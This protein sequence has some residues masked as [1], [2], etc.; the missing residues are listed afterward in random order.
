[1]EQ[2]PLYL[3]I[4]VSIL[5]KC[6]TALN[7][8]KHRYACVLLD[9]FDNITQK[10]CIPLRILFQRLILAAELSSRLGQITKS[11]AE[12]EN[13]LELFNS[14]PDLKFKLLIKAGRMEACVARNNISVKHL[15]EALGLAESIENNSM[16]AEAYFAIAHMFSPKYEGLAFYFLRHAELFYENAKDCRNL[17][18]VRIHRALLSWAVSRN[19]SNLRN[20]DRF[21][22]EAEKLISKI[23]TENLNPHDLTYLKYVKGVIL[24]DEKLLE[25]LLHENVDVDMLPDKCRHGEMIIGICIEKGLFEKAEQ[26]L[27]SYEKDAKKVHGNGIEIENHVRL[28][29][30]LINR[31]ERSVY[32]PFRI[33][34]ESME[35]ANLFDIL[36]HYSLCDE[37]WALDNSEMRCLFP[38]YRQEGQFEAIRMPDNRTILYPCAIAFN[39]F[40]RGQSEYHKMAQPSLYRKGMSE[41]MQFVERVRYEEFKRCVESSPLTNIFQNG[42]YLT[43]PNGCQER[44]ELSVDTLALAQ[45]YGI[46]TELM[47]LTTDKFVAAFFSTTDCKN[48]IYTPI[49]DNRKEPGVFYRYCDTLRL[50]KD[51]SYRLR[52]VGLQP[53]S[54]PGEQKGLVY[55]MRPNENFND[56]VMSKD[57]FTHDSQIASFIFNYMNRSQKLFPKSPLEVHADAILNSS[58]L[59]RD[60]FDAA[61]RE[62]Y[63]N[64]SEDVLISYLKE[65]KIAIVDGIHFSFSEVEKQQCLASW[66]MNKDKILS[67]II[68]RMCYGS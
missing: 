54:R 64:T 40:Y 12:I 67:K 27:V 59:S 39:V 17:S 57:F 29:R 3:N 35:S 25:E 37:I 18:I 7:N 14:S 48:G 43:Y 31:K 55:E 1:M 68:V 21:R 19:Y 66:E 52:A 2:I 36:N 50:G 33:E 44:L 49:V 15:S 16:I 30:D 26:F 45:H 13:N 6:A 63:P 9:E 28:L 23:S 20:V 11:L 56:A 41:A 65:M 58:E 61:K 51:Y 34:R 38:T 47:D 4:A 62:F 32:I 22:N 60:A 42:I 8:K 24:R 46:K 10:K 53:F 5:N